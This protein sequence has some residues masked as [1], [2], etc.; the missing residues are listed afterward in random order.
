M[1]LSH[2]SSTSSLRATSIALRC[3]AMRRQFELK[4]SSKKSDDETV[5]LDY[6]NHQYG[7]IPGFCQNLIHMI[8]ASKLGQDWRNLRYNGVKVL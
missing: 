4:F 3:G 7:L 6:T 5:L 2:S 1:V 8:G